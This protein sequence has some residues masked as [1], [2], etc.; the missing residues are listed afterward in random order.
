VSRRVARGLPN[1]EI[2]QELYISDT[3]V[4]TP[5]THILQ[6]L[7]LRD[8]VQAVVLTYQTGLFDTDARP[9]S[10]GAERSAH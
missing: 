8:R 6:K 4:K 10:N 2:G 9:P 1:A 7:D 3:T 5:I